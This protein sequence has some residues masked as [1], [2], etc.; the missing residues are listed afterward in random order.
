[1]NYPIPERKVLLGRT[2]VCDLGQNRVVEYD[3]NGKQTWQVSVKGPYGAHGLSNGHRLVASFQERSVIEYDNKSRVVWRKTG[4]PGM[5]CRVWRLPSGNTLVAL[6]NPS[7]VIEV[8]PSGDVTWEVTVPGTVMD[9]RRAPNGNTLVCLHD[10]GTVVELDRSGKTVWEMPGLQRPMAAQP[11]DNGNVLIAVASGGK[12]IEVNRRH[13][14][15][16]SKAGL[17]NPL[18]AQ[19]LRN[20]NTL[21]S[22]LNGVREFDRR[23]SLV[24][25]LAELNPRRSTALRLGTR[26]IIRSRGSSMKRIWRY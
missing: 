22:D 25:S 10:R 15:V 4:L 1:M 21:I 5:P 8:Q 9:A 16:W 24:A 20:G 11:L 26:R 19:R 13:Q 7:K 17:S 23:G 2:L 6:A 12:V 18:D 14:I 3:A